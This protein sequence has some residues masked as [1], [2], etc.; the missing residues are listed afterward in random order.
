VSNL[1]LFPPSHLTFVNIVPI[2][3]SQA[4]TGPLAKSSWDIAAA[5]SIMAGTSEPDD[6]LSTSANRFRRANYTQFLTPSGLKSLRNGVPHQ[7][8]LNNARFPAYL[9]MELEGAFDTLRK[10]VDPVLFGNPD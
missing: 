2:S 8:R 1:S 9:T 6:R 3:S 4:T 5:L 7:L 10:A